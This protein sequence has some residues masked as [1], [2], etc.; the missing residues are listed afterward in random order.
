MD[1]IGL[2][3][4]WAKNYGSALQCYALKSEIEARGYD[5]QVLGECETG[6]DKISHYVK[7]LFSVLFLT[8]RY[9]SFFT[10]YIVMRNAIKFS[11]NSISS[12]S[13]FRLNRFCETMLR[14]QKYSMSRLRGLAQCDE[15]RFF[16]AGSDQIWAGNRKIE[17]FFFLTFV[18]PEKRV[19]FAP[20]FGTER[21]EDFNRKSFAREISKFSK[22]SV[23]EES[24][25]I[26]IKD[27]TGREVKRIA[28]P[29]ILKTRNEWSEFARGSRIIKK[30]KSSKYIFVHFLDEPSD[31]A[32]QCL[33]YLSNMKGLKV[34]GFA[35][36]HESMCNIRQYHMVE[37]DPVD[38]VALIEHAEYV[39]TDSFHTSLFSIIFEKVFFTFVRQ[40]RHS[41]S[42]QS[43]IYT[44]LKLTDYN[45]R[46]I[47]NI[48][49]FKEELNSKL[50]SC[51]VI[52]EQE[53][54]IAKAFLTD[55]IGFGKG[56]KS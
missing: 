46:L 21:V 13:D 50:H 52:L 14:P 28:D 56:D 5:C 45:S 51:D 32:L 8:I 27:L 40:Y 19:A 47:K 20:S 26:I 22:I 48:D 36:P 17:G 11:A 10:K 4:L 12:D 15:Y 31:V 49:G 33:N 18:P 23:R 7:E 9:P 41:G 6:L 30:I 34:F 16:I 3:T 37:G 1:K 39:L 25:Q 38:Y 2:I 44:L 43:R 54:N 29:T 53:R 35:Y 42:Q 24:G 55:A